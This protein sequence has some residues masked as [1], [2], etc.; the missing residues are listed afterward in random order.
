M[1]SGGCTLGSDEEMIAREE[2][3]E[4]GQSEENRRVSGFGM[5][6]FREGSWLQT[7][8]FQFLG[9]RRGLWEH[10]TVVFMSSGS[11]GVNSSP[12]PSVS[13]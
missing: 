8:V 3:E 12:P 5:M 1:D 11:G 4:G 2:E 6:I 10:W 13:M 7:P 9:A